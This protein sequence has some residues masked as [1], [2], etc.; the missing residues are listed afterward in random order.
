[1]KEKVKSILLV[2]LVLLSLGL[3]GAINMFD[4][5][6]SSASISEYYPQ[7]TLGDSKELEQL[8]MPAEIVVH[9]SEGKSYLLNRNNKY[10]NLI[11]NEVKKFTFF[12]PTL[13]EEKINWSNFRNSK[14]G[15]E[16]IFA[17]PYD[18]S[19]LEAIF[20]LMVS[21]PNLQ[22]I[23]RIWFF[24]D[25]MLDVGVY[26]ISEE[27]DKVYYSRTIN[28]APLINEYL[29]KVATEQQYSYHLASRDIQGEKVEKGYYL[30]IG[31]LIADSISTT[32]LKFSEN[33]II[34]M[35]FPVPS[36]VRLFYSE[37]THDSVYYTDGIS[38]LE[39]YNESN[40]FSFYQPV[41][42]ETMNFNLERELAATIKFIN[43]HGG[44]DGDYLLTVTDKKFEESRINFRFTKYVEG[45]P[46]YTADEGY[47]VIQAEAIN[48]IVSNYNRSTLLADRVTN[49]SQLNMSGTELL[50]A[51]A[52]K[53][54]RQTQINDINL[55]Y[56]LTYLKGNLKLEPYWL[57][58][59]NEA[60]QLLI[61]ALK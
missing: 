21:M 34:Q 46:I 14:N 15:L 48:N 41:L 2:F 50:T 29:D 57:I 33:N 3:I 35:I 54:I 61:A 26:F 49:Y 11:Y 51:L 55:V 28:T 23:D 44:W 30:P 42:E 19:S 1:M 18:A 6:R 31:S 40:D 60:E 58:E 5:N 4:F 36:S 12:S 20:N 25:D 24:T 43:Q 8:V 17:N 10:Y 13:V 7:I 37:D 45:I 27:L 38:S 39:Y 56:R 9:A 59:Y 52:K 47:G 53:S 22:S 32:Y 16:L